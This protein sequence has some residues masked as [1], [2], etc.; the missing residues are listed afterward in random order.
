MATG[1][2]SN[3]VSGHPLVLCVLDVPLDE[4]WERISHR[5]SD[6]PRSAFRVGKAEFERASTLFQRPTDEETA[7]FD[8][9]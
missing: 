3:E 8:S 5:N 1:D 7:L 6:L 4:L 2:T 9:G